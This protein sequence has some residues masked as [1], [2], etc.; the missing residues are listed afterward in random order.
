MLL[1]EISK[2]TLQK[3]YYNTDFKQSDKQFLQQDTGFFSDA[4]GKDWIH[5]KNTDYYTLVLA[6]L[7]GIFNKYVRTAALIKLSR[8]HKNINY[9]E[10]DTS[11]EA[12]ALLDKF[13]NDLTKIDISDYLDEDTC[14]APYYE[15]FLDNDIT[16]LAKFNAFFSNK[17][18]LMRFVRRTTKNDSSEIMSLVND[19]VNFLQN[20]AETKFVT[21]YRGISIDHNKLLEWY[22]HDKLIKTNPLRILKYIDN[23][24]KEFNSYSTDISIAEKFAKHSQ[25]GK[26]YDD[27]LSKTPT[28]DYIIISGKAAKHNINFAFSA[29]LAG[30]SFSTDEQ[31]LCINSYEPLTDI[32]VEQYKFNLDVD[33]KFFAAQKRFGKCIAHIDN[34]YIFKKCITDL[35]LNVI[36]PNLSNYEETKLEHTILCTIPT[37][38]KFINKHFLLNTVTLHTSG[39]AEC[40]YMHVVY[41]PYIL[42]KQLCYFND[43]DQQQFFDARMQL[44]LSSN[45]DKFSYNVETTTYD[46]DVIPFT[47]SEG[48]KVI[49]YADKFRDE[50]I[51]W[52]D[53]VTLQ[54]FS[55]HTNIRRFF[56]DTTN[57]NLILAACIEPGYRYGVCRQ[58]NVQTDELGDIVQNE[59]L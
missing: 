53:S 40:R 24:A 44:I 5:V 31:E 12:D 28:H 43:S 33:D 27:D 51:V 18:N 1:T 46:W 21:V 16:T 4:Q 3:I 42:N 45:S 34:V 23:T 58:Y 25:D 6:A 10:I 59:H 8:K 19:I 49:V 48:G 2:Q 15:A 14:F 30:K 29:Y 22:K 36:V 50:H 11:Q 38:D 26:F 39:N 13:G 55:K 32:K 56:K 20:T 57:S 7:D 35:K 41:E 47:A 54:P 17:A 52:L 37:D 9:E